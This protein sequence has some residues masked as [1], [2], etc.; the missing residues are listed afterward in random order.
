[1]ILFHVALGLKS[2]L[3]HLSR[4][5]T[6]AKDLKKKSK[7][8]FLISRDA[9]IAEKILNQ[10]NI[11]T[12]FYENDQKISELV[13][14]FPKKIKAI[15]ID[16]SDAMYVKKPDLLKEY[17]HKIKEKKIKLIVIDGLFKDRIILKDYPIFDILIQPYIEVNLNERVS[18]TKHLRGPNYIILDKI[19][20]KNIQFREKNIPKLAKSILI[21]FGGSDPTLLTNEFCKFLTLNF[22]TFKEQTF[23]IILGP[24]MEK[25]NQYI[26]ENQMKDF[27]NI[28]IK[29]NIFNLKPFFDKSDLAILASGSTSR[30]EAASCGTPALFFGINKDHEIQCKIYAETGCALYLGQQNKIIKD[31]LLEELV[32]IINDKSR[33]YMMSKL[34]HDLIDGQGSFRLACEIF[35]IGL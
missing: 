22:E 26:I 8:G 7:V 18:A 28:I 29:N 6:L 32:S 33:R 16:I 12:F 24:Y 10:S 35:K 30:Y 20:K 27:G 13:Q 17:F 3:G 15:I 4:S 34:G 11:S 14:I 9:V 1:M 23:I 25:K 5:I 31:S 21:S 19:F 2:G